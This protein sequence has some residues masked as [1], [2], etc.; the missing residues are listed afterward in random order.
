MADIRAFPGIRYDRARVAMGDVVAPPYD[1]LSEE[2]VALYNQRSPY[3]V[4]HVTRP[5]GDYGGA[6]RKLAEWERDGVLRRDEPAMYLHEVRWGSRVR[7]DV[8]AA[9]RLE[10]YEAG[11][12]LPHE[13]T[14]RGPKEDRLALL[15][16]TGW[17]LEP[18]W[19]LYDGR[20]SELPAL[21]TEALARPAELEFEFPAGEHHRWWTVSD[22]EWAARASSSLREQPVLI[23]DGH[24]RYE[25]TLA[26]S[27]EIGGPADAASRFTL[28]LLTDLG[29]PGLMVQPTHRILKAGVTVTG[30]F[31]VGSLPEM[32]AALEGRV[33]AGIYAKG[34]YQVIEFDDGEVPV[35]ELHRQVI[36]NVLGKRNPEDFLSYTRDPQ[37]AKA[38]VDEG[39]AVSAFFL[40]PPDLAVVLAKAREG[41][42]MPQKTT[43]FDPKP[44]SGMVF[45]RLDPNTELRS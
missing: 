37:E 10:P 42:T 2:Q 21:L 20:Q 7:R 22:P 41:M 43:Y 36:D 35:V 13:R 26:Y 9:L 18:L 32:L 44:P 30:G 6:A 1:V 11:V 24:H 4:V 45:H 12:V 17:S 33:A 34:K 38:A 39:R 29:D 19:F 23:A 14:H 28:A 25:T 5:D 15:R 27:Q 16:A 8:V 40:A 3:N 31:E